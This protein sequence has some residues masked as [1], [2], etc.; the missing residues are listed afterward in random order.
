MSHKIKENMEELRAEIKKLCEEPI[1]YRSCE[2]LISCHKAYKILCEIYGKRD[3]EV[4]HTRDDVYKV[5]VSVK[6]GWTP[7]FDRQ[8]AMAWT[9]SM[10]NADGTNGPHWSMEETS[11]LLKQYSLD[12]DPSEFWAVINSLYSDYCEALR[13]TS[14]STPEVYV[15]LAEA[16]I[17]DKDAV[18]NKAAAYYAYVVEH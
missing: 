15:R 5:D 6:E 8:M 12:C 11:R 18:P 7:R 13:G 17:K 16:W 3:H 14:A 4:E 10:V 1:T 2:R 9:K